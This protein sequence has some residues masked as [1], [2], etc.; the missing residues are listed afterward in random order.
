MTDETAVER[1]YPDDVP[2]APESVAEPATAVA[3]DPTPPNVTAAIEVPEKYELAMEGV[4]LDPKLISEAEPIF[5]ELGLSNKQAN[6]LLPI[7]PKLM[8]H[9][10]TVLMDQMIDAG[11]K[12]R[13]AWLD[14][15]A[16]DPEIGGGRRSET[17]RL[18]S[19][20]M[21]IMGF[22]K[23]HPFRVALNE[24]GFGNHPD[25]IRLLRRIGST[26][27]SSEGNAG[28]ELPAWKS[29]YPND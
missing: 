26:A 11:A 18:A 12:Q 8:D 28:G 1:L 14:A 19:K 5:R 24:S 13:K 2:A 6:A 3:A 4:S 7:A 29:L 20:G 27:G 16:A 22:G 15:F 25:M 23:N 10:Q 9:A 21:E 17:E